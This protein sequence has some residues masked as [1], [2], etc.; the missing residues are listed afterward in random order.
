MILGLALVVSFTTFGANKLAFAAVPVC[1][2]TCASF[3]CDGG[4]ENCGVII[5]CCDSEDIPCTENGPSTTIAGCF[6]NY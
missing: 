5:F 3:E 4:Q 2:G 1:Q 6:H